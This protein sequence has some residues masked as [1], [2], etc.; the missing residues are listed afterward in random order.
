MSPKLEVLL[1]INVLNYLKYFS[2]LLKCIPR[3][4]AYNQS[5]SR[6]RNTFRIA[7]LQLY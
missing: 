5:I 7:R 6:P 1:K 4:F 2:Y 3:N